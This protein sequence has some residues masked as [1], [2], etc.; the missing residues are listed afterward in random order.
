MEETDFARRVKHIGGRAYVVG[1]WVRDREMGVSG[2][3]KDYA[4][5][6]VT[7]SAFNAAFSAAFKTG[8]R[9]PVYRL[10]ISQR[11]C[12]VSLARSET[13]TGRG[14]RGFEAAPSPL[15]N[16]EGDL[17]R[18]DSTVNAMAVDL[19]TGELVDPYGGLDDL[20]NGIIRAVSEHFSD[21]PVR[22][23]RA[24][25]Q[26]AQFGFRI[27]PGTVRL[28][29]RCRD[30]LADEPTERLVNELRLALPCRKP[31]V[32]FTCLDAAGLLDAAYPAVLAPSGKGRAAPCRG[33]DALDRAAAITERP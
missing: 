10:E 4:V 23:L 26:A 15:V 31:S 30:E 24:A 17:G 19:E 13:K 6:G 20:R 29:A 25:R 2:R 9:F 3:D 22:A 18:R 28:M 33:I 1:G 12:D 27:D 5:T 32:F 7:E 8:G 21:D 16:I 11:T 14:Y